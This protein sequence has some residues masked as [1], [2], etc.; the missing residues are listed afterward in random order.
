MTL[1][2]LNF[3]LTC[4]KSIIEINNFRLFKYSYK[5]TE[6]FEKENEKRLGE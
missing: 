4:I 6:F 2:Q 3:S 5:T 1:S